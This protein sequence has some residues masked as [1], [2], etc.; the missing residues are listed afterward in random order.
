MVPVGVTLGMPFPTGLR[1]VGKPPSPLVPRAQAWAVNGFFT[2]IGSVGAMIL[3]YV[4]G[5]TTVPITA[6][7]RYA[8]ALA[9][10]RPIGPGGLAQTS[11]DRAEEFAV[12]GRQYSD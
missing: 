5:F 12:A 6:A 4:L 2:V 1:L 10:I 8:A 9:A 7:A 3:G 11:S